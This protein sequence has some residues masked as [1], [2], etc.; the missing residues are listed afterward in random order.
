MFFNV[1]IISEKQTDPDVT[2]EEE[3]QNMVERNADVNTRCI[4]IHL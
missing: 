2:M 1:R 4:A 3:I